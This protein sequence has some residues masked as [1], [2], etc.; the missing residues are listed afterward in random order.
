MDKKHRSE[1]IM[2]ETITYNNQPQLLAD[3]NS[4]I[5]ALEYAATGRTGYNFYNAKG[6]LLKA[7]PYTNLA[8]EARLLARKLFATGANRGD[9]VALIAD[10]TPEFVTLFYACRYAGLVPFALPIPVNLGSHDI[11]VRQL[12]G[13]LTTS[14]ATLALA[15]KHYIGF[16]EEAAQENNTLIWTG[17][18]EE[19]AALTPLDVDLQP[20]RNDEVAYLQ[21]TSGSTRT[22][23]AVVITEQA[24]MSNLRGICRHGLKMHPGDRCA[25][26]L[27]FYHDMG[28]VGFVLA[29]MVAQLSV[30]FLRTRDFAVRPVQWLRIISRNR[31]SLAFSPTFGFKLCALRVRSADLETLDLSSWR[32]AGVGAEM[33]RPDILKTFADKFSGCGFDPKAFLPCYGLAEATLAVTFAEL[34]QGCRSITV[35]TRTLS[36][37]RI[38]LRIES[39]ERKSSEF[40]DCGR[41]MPGHEVRIVDNSGRPLA[42]LRVGRVLTRGPNLMQGYLDDSEVSRDVFEEGHWLDTGDQG[43]MH[44]GNLFITGRRTDV[45][46]INGRNI[47]A[48]DIEELTEYEPS[49]NSREASAFGVDDTDGSTMIVLVVESRITPDAEDRQSVINRLQQAVYKTFGVHCFVELVPPHTLPRTSSGKLSRTAARTGFLERHGPE[50]F[51][52]RNIVRSIDN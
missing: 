27:P 21:F 34:E 35:D 37:K 38:A 32:A 23:R 11:Y 22:P 4:L 5:E 26:W 33:I 43:F 8:E 41:P 39:E 40:V 44:E 14:H 31:C 1:L 28:L 24:L 3:F 20:G 51:S 42:D 47:R 52:P 45:I 19:A 13:M 6:E 15:G 50:T 25:S 29:P 7:L 10:T 12:Q 2:A 30:D 48:Q 36:E 46:I 49:V 9:R 16:L 18:P 17:T